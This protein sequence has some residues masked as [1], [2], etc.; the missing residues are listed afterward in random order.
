MHLSVAIALGHFLMHDPPAR[1]HPLHIASA[2]RAF[3][4]KAI[5]VFHT[6]REHIG[7]GFNA[8][9]RMPRKALFKIFRQFIAK[10]V[11]E[12]KRIHFRGILKSKSA[13]QFDAGPFQGWG[14]LPC[15]KCRS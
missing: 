11:K 6:A 1:G 15:F 14:G 13:V 7:D 5:A 12:Q 2:E 9:V 4:S 10:I 3:I 8:A